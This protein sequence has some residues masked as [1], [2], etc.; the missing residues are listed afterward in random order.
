VVSV[1]SDDQTLEVWSL[2]GGA[3]LS[4]LAG[5]SPAVGA[6]TVTAD[7]RRTISASDD[8]TLKVWDLEHGGI[9]CTFAAES[10][11]WACAAAPDGVEIVAGDTLGRVHFLHLDSVAPGP[12]V[13]TAW[14]SPDSGAPAFGC[15][16]CRVWSEV[17][18][19]NLGAELPCPNCG[20]AVKLN[21][22]VIAA[23]WRPVAAA[24][25]RD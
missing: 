16:H 6:L 7:G 9:L 2:E 18:E 4:A 15:L 5:H 1:A 10:G 3:E 19:E 8:H 21:E 17:S 14:L 20:R 23:D 12:S 22:F 11:L 13:C 25:R 24:W